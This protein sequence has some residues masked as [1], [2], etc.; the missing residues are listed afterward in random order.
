MAALGAE[1]V[2]AFKVEEK[3]NAQK[4]DD[5][6]KRHI[7]RQLKHRDK[8]QKAMFQDVILAYI[9][10]LERSNQR[11]LITKGIL[12]SG[13]RYPASSND[14]LTS[15]ISKNDDLKKTTGELAYQ[16][17][18]LQQEIK[19]KDSVLE[20]QHARMCEVKRDLLGVQAEDGSLKVRVAEVTEGNRLLKREY[21]S[22][23][24]RHHDMDQ[25]FREEKLRGQ[26]LLEELVRR[27]Q[28]AAV[29]M[30]SRNERRVRAR[31]ASLQK[32]LET[33]GKVKVTIDVGSVSAPAS[34]EASPKSDLAER[35]TTRLFRSA[36]VT[37]PPR[38]LDSIKE[39]FDRKKRR[40][41]SLCLSLEE[42]LYVP[43][44]ICLA[45][46]VPARALHVLDAHELGINAV[47]FSSSC[48][49]L[50]TGGTDRSIKLWDV[51]AGMLHN[52]GTL[53]GSNEGITSIEFDQTGTRV[54]A[55]SYD[56]SALFWRLDDSAP[57]LTLT[58]HSRKVTAAKFKCSLRQVVTGS[59]DRTVKIWDLHRAACIQTIEVL[60]YCSD[61][62]CSEHVIVSGHYDRKIR[63]W[64]SRAASCTQEVPLQGKVT[65]LDISTDHRQLL[66]CSR[67]ESLQ[68]VDLRMNNSRICFRAEGFK[69]GCD[70]T[71]A[72][73][74]PD[75]SYLAAGSADGAV[76]IWNVNSGNLETRLPDMHSS[77]INAVAWSGSG[78]YVVSV[79]KSRRAV[80]WS[81]I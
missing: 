70:S 16:V 59:A 21:D 3:I 53:D 5:S 41:N 58:G 77:S 34:R 6:W 78:E 51:K 36:S 55:A 81:D 19:I 26:E 67:D 52:R 43:V 64:D 17:L 48:N 7:I 80:L 27:K 22:L 32:E 57:K 60:S 44:G 9:N 1:C 40:G 14:S 72:I 24:E 49:L 63:F 73:F 69:C 50:A 10:L 2:E 15:L 66:S 79:D 39:L 25:T 68:V 65:S 11:A 29:R 12:G 54:L 20:E 33:A 62:V 74:S 4:T 35:R 28:H 61:V 45:A 42:E 13:S 37:S 23:L 47:R 46:R 18:E 30:N 75:G 56:K 38:I 31:E 71:K 8:Y 76:Y